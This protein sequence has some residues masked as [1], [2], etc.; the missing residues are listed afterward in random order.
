MSDKRTYIT[1]IGT[2]FFPHLRT[3]EE[4]EGNEIGY[5]C[6][7]ILSKE[8]TDNLENFLLKELEAAKQ[9]EEF[10]GKKWSSE[11]SMGT[12]ETKDGETYFKFKK[13]ASYV[14]KKTR[15]VVHTTVPIFDSKGKPLP[16]DIEIGNGSR[17][18]VAY[19]ILPFHMSKV[20]N[21]LSLR[22]EAVQV[23]ELRQYGANAEN[24][25]FKEEEGYSAPEQE[26]SVFD[27]GAGEG[28]F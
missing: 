21:G 23:I 6:K 20:N 13:K 8:E 9:S 16:K 26:S 10:K 14:S 11:P 25:G 1:P 7:I 15:E 22:L 24:F 18:R 12:G 19:S 27:D 17:V 3:P 28:D 2:A 4:F 5:T